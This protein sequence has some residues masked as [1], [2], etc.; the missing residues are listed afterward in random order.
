[1]RLYRLEDSGEPVRDI[2][3]RLSALGYDCGADPRGGA[4]VGV[5]N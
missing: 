4:G 2:Q 1:M 3:D 5:F